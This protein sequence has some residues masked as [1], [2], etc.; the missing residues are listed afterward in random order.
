MIIVGR[1]DVSSRIA[2]TAGFTRVVTFG[3]LAEFD[4]WRAASTSSPSIR[5]DVAAALAEVGCSRATLPRKLCDAFDAIA[6]RDTVPELAELEQLW[7]S[8][9]SFYRV[10]RERIPEPPSAF[11]RRV[12]LRHAARLLALGLSKKEAAHRAGFSSVDQMRRC[13]K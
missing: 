1:P 13:A 5:E 7:P 12:R 4:R 11:L 8:R 9:R 10:W 3:S 2:R 6:V